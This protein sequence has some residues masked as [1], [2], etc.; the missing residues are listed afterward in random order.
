MNVQLLTFLLGFVI[1]PLAFFIPVKRNSQCETGREYFIP[2]ILDVYWGIGLFLSAIVIIFQTSTPVLN[3]VLGTTIA[4]P[5]DAEFAY[6]SIQVYVAIIIALLTAVSQ[7]LKYK[8]TS[9][10]Y[11]WKNADSR[12]DHFIPWR[13]LCDFWRNQLR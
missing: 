10:S 2:R 3:K 5:D 12:N 13:S 7:Y 1:P 11:F 4:P 9:R 8:D 6:N